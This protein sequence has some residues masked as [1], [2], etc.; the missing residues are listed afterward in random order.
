MKLAITC[1]TCSLAV[2]L[3]SCSTAYA[4]PS[5]EVP[6]TLTAE[7]PDACLM[8]LPGSPPPPYLLFR[9]MED[10]A[11]LK[12]ARNRS[13]LFDSIKFVPL[14]E[15]K[16]V[17]LSFGGEVRERYEYWSG[18]NFGL[19]TPPQNS[20]WLQRVFLHAALHVNDNLIIFTQ[21][22]SALEEGRLGGPRP[23]DR[24]EINLHQA[25]VGWTFFKNGN[26]QAAVS[27]GRQELGLGIG[28]ILDPREGPN[29][30]QSFDGIRAILHFKDW[31]VDAFGYRPVET[32]PYSFDNPDPHVRM[33][34]LYSTRP[35]VPNL[36]ADLYYVG[37]SDDSAV[38][39]NGAGDEVRHTFGTRLYGTTKSFDYDWEGGYQTGHTGPRDVKAWYLSTETGYR[40]V[41][42]FGSPHLSIKAD[43]FSGDEHPG[44]GS[45]GTFSSPYS[46]GNYYSEAAPIGQQNII[47]VHPELD[48]YP[49]KNVSF[50]A[51]PLFY[52]RESTGDGIYNF[53]GFPLAPDI[54]VDRSRFVGTELYAEANCQINPHTSFTVAYDH[55]IRGTYLQ[56]IPGTKDSDYVATWL[57]VKF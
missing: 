20:S 37:R 23:T 3:G 34:G 52:W 54:P 25:F 29:T 11:Y 35:I 32:N 15:S 12:Q 30:R 42:D 33:W 5:A 56:N 38:Y 9:D 24:D 2:L 19:L 21:M 31:E 39:W 41:D 10:Y 17:Y 8:G 57:T 26:G 46:R 55:F 7:Q 43:A 49:I 50:T 45:L 6:D 47:V 48:W 13:D 36:R 22:S 27:V 18:E 14:T 44:S 40:F 16:N 51:S 28:R 4:V 1:I 53:G